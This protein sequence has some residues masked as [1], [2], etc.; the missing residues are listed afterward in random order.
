MLWCFIFLS[1]YLYL[2]FPP[3]STE[4]SLISPKPSPTSLDHGAFCV[5]IYFCCSCTISLLCFKPFLFKLL[6]R[7]DIFY[8]QNSSLVPPCEFLQG[9]LFTHES[10]HGSVLLET[11]LASAQLHPVGAGWSSPPKW[12]HF[13]LIPRHHFRQGGFMLCLLLLKLLIVIK[14]KLCCHKSEMAGFKRCCCKCHHWLCSL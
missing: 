3:H 5:E 11:T 6:E 9:L 10:A 14:T 7:S 8:P 4:F 12:F 13:Q 2:L 1:L